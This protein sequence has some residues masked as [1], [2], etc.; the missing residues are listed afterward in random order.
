M[1]RFAML[2]I[3]VA[4]LATSIVLVLL[5]ML[6]PAPVQTATIENEY[7]TVTDDAVIITIPEGTGEL[8]DAGEA[9]QIIEG[10][11]IL[12]LGAQDELIIH[13]QDSV[14]HSLGFFFITAGQTIRQRFTR[15]DI[16]ESSCTFR[17]DNIK[18]IVREGTS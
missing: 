7:V 2:F 11:I 12:T 16:F 17:E 13:N 1:F 4:S 3:L 15:P 6:A 9:P 8:V 5:P 14:D 10:D 18:V